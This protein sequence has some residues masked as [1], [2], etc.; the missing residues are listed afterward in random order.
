M[1][2]FLGIIFIIG[3][4][5]LL[6]LENYWSTDKFIRN[7]KIQTVMTRR[8]F[9][10]ILQNLPFSNNDNDDKT[11]KLYKIRPVIENLNKVFAESLSNSRFQSV[12]EH[13][14]KFTGRSSI[15]Q[16][17]KNKPIKWGFKYWYRYDIEADCVY[18]LELYQ[19]QKEKRELNLG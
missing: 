19:G 6:C 12:D 18:Q 9:Q 4:N 5:K 2:E 13:M 1:K 3:I 14:Y 15:K 8:R 10:S 11:D 7:E 16:D 17:I